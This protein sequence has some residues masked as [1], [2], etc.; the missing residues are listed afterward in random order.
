M[1]FLFAVIGAC[2]GSFVYATALRIGRSEGI[3]LDKIKHT[4][5]RSHCD[6][7][8]HTLAPIDLIPVLSFIFLRGRCRY[9]RRAIGVG[10][11]VVEVL[12]AVFGYAIATVD[13]SPASSIVLF[14]SCGVLVFTCVYDWIYFKILDSVMLPSIVI[15]FVCSITVFHRSWIDLCI[16]AAI[17]GGFFLLQYL[18]SRGR[19]IGDGDIRLGVLMGVMLGWRATIVALFLAYIIGATYAIVLLAQKKASLGARIP[20]GTFLTLATMVALLYGQSIW[21]WYLDLILYSI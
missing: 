11:G 13:F 2:I 18:V 4:P 7:C 16:G 15:F 17:G 9:C 10:H 6:H 19:W 20:F 12:S 1:E 21:E 14:L 3:V 8:G 5:A